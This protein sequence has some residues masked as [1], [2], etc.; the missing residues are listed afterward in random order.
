MSASF[1]VVWVTSTIAFLI[2][3]ADSGLAAAEHGRDDGLT[4]G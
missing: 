2:A 4:V 1:A 3:S